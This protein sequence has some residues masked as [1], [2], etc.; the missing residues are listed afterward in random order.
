M[1][2]EPLLRAHGFMRIE[3][4]PQMWEPDAEDE[5][6]LRVLGEMIVIGLGRG[7]ELADL[8]LSV[9]NITA[10]DEDDDEGRWVPPG[11]YVAVSV[12]GGG[13]WED[14]VWRSGQG[15]TTGLLC[16]VGPA[17]DPA[18]AVYAYTRDLGSEGSVTALFPR[19]IPPS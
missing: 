8:T 3:H 11:D 9:A 19:L 4:P 14:D 18:G 5:P 16:N 6:F 10:E 12:R 2:L 7:N 13:R 17:A 1:N 15:P